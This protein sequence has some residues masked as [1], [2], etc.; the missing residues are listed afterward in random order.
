MGMS[1]RTYVGPYLRCSVR[2]RPRTKEIKVCPHFKCRFHTEANSMPDGSIFCPQCGRK[3]EDKIIEVEGEVDE[4]LDDI[5]LLEATNERLVPFNC[6]Y[7]EMGT[8]LFISNSTKPPGVSLER[9]DGVGEIR[10]Y[11][12]IIID[13]ELAAF[14]KRHAKDLEIA[15]EHYGEDRVEVC[16]GLMAAYG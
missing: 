7:P 14:R 1:Y 5:D 6:S 8:H 10:E 11:N 9:G 4:V 15:Y 3:A 2:T 12:G 13:Q 16:W